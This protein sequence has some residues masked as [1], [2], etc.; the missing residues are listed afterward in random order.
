MTVPVIDDRKYQDLR[1]EGLRRVR[2]HNPEWTN[3][4]KSDPGV[5]LVEVFAFLTESLLYRAAQIPERNRRKFLKLLGVSLQPATAAQGLVA[6]TND[7]G[8]L[9]TTQLPTSFEVRAG[10]LSFRV[11]RGLDVLPVEGRIY[12]K[13][14]LKNPPPRMREYYDQLYAAFLKAPLPQTA[15][16]Y[17]SVPLLDT[18]G[19]DI[20][21]DTVD[22]SFW[23]ALV[24]RKADV[25]G[26][27]GAALTT[28]LKQVRDAIGAK[29][30]TLGLV[31]W[32][33]DAARTLNRNVRV[34][35]PAIARDRRCVHHTTYFQLLDLLEAT[36]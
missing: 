17:E 14:E 20:G 28:R 10:Q 36:P 13:R 34:I 1:D 32:L 24:A 4:N 12:Y 18:D 26:L 27:S 25:A 29:T 2:V 22:S 30:V 6:F 7:R 21:N 5:T 15:K 8:P 11:D 33:T 16:L 9:E 19:V 3:F 31:P 23:V 35:T